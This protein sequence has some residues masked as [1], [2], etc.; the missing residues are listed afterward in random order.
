MVQVLRRTGKPACISAAAHRAQA[1]A[2]LAAGQTPGWRSARY[3]A[4][5]SDSQTTVDLSWRQGTRPAGENFRKGSQLEPSW[6]TTSRSS[7]E[8]PRA[9]ISTQGRSDQDE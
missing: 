2:P 3:S 8:I 4:M 6:K 1:R 5:P 9:F 7:K